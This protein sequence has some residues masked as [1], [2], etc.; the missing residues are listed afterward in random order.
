MGG[1]AQHNDCHGGIQS[2]GTVT[3]FQIVHMNRDGAA[4]KGRCGSF[5][6]GNLRLTGLKLQDG[7]P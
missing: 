4:T 3:A 6:G 2:H 1:N 5:K 7:C